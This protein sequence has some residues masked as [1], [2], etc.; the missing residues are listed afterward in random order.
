MRDGDMPEARARAV[1]RHAQKAGNKAEFGLRARR[2][3]M[4]SVV[5]SKSLEPRLDIFPHELR[6]A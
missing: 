5:P 3:E 2:S 1:W 6:S 4:C